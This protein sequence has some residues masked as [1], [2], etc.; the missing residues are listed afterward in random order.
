MKRSIFA[1]RCSGMKRGQT[2]RLLLGIIQR[3]CA[4]QF[5]VSRS[6]REALCEAADASEF[7]CVPEEDGAFR[8]SPVVCQKKHQ[9]K[10]S[11]GATFA[12]LFD[13]LDLAIK[14]NNNN[15]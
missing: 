14:R 13:Q 5:D 4:S 6:L 12:D 1:T 9:L 3:H 10:R 7:L 11:F 15:N 8:Y 2:E